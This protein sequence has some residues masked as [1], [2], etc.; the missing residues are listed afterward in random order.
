MWFLLSGAEKLSNAVQ[1]A[2]IQPESYMPFCLKLVKKWNIYKNRLTL[3]HK[4]KQHSIN[5]LTTILKGTQGCQTPNL[6]I[7]VI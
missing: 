4:W 1:G 5:S 6:P 2:S 3:C 7:S